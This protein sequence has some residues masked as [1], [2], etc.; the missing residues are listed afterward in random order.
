MKE[1]A[2]AIGG[3]GILAVSAWLYM[4]GYQNNW[5]IAMAVFGVLE[6]LV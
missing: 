3:V 1:I 2:S 5:V 6:A 4:N